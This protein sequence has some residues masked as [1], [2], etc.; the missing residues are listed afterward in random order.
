[1]TNNNPVYTKSKAVITRPLKP[2]TL[3]VPIRA[4]QVN[5]NEVYLLNEVAGR[6]WELI[7]GQRS[8]GQIITMITQEYE[9][10]AEEAWADFSN[11]LNQLE[12]RAVLG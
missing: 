1:M 6:M 4:G 5:L 3:I 12:D 2:E 11:L 10:S 9:V 8:A 7:D